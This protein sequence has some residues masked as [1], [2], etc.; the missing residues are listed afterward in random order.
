M[1]NLLKLQKAVLDLPRSVDPPSTTKPVAYVI[2]PHATQDLKELAASADKLF[3][4]DPSEEIDP[5]V[6]A[7]PNIEVLTRIEKKDCLVLIVDAHI[8]GKQYGSELT[9]LENLIKMIGAN[10]PIMFIRAEDPT[11][12]GLL[13]QFLIRVCNYDAYYWQ[14]I[15]NTGESDS[16]WIAGFNKNLGVNFGMQTAD[17]TGHPSVPAEAPIVEYQVVQ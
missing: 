4:F 15:N 3:Y 12:G 14:R 16:I 10:N 7:I 11:Q 6:R 5:E 2:G 13:V 17:Q 1:N 9:I 8:A